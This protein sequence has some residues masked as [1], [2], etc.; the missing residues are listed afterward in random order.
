M[1][2]TVQKYSL[3]CCACCYRIDP[4]SCFFS[5]RVYDILS[6]WSSA[7][8][9]ALNCAQTVT[10]RSRPMHRVVI[11]VTRVSRYLFSHLSCR[12]LLPW[13][14]VFVHCLSYVVD[15]RTHR[16]SAP[17]PSLSSCYEVLYVSDELCWLFCDFL[18]RRIRSGFSFSIAPHE[19]M[20]RCGLGW[21]V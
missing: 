17:C 6:I 16:I 15:A 18:F 10:S 2:G 19:A 20:S 14:V 9:F 12:L 11:S 4:V 5:G 3:V 13:L 1:G 8:R 21:Y 7:S